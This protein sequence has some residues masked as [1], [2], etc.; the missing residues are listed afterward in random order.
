MRNLFRVQSLLLLS[1]LVGVNLPASSALVEEI[2]VNEQSDSV[3][4]EEVNISQQSDIDNSISYGDN[5]GK[6]K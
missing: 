6:K 5:C 1:A 2:N 3:L 4:A